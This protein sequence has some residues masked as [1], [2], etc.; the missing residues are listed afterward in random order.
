[1]LN[2]VGAGM[3]GDA[4]Q[5]LQDMDPG[6]AAEMAAKHKTLIVGFK[7]AHY[8]GPEWTPVENAVK[9]GETAGLPIMVDFG[10]FRPERPFE[11]LVTKNCA[12]ATCIH[13]CFCRWSRC[14]TIQAGCGL[15]CPRLANVESFST[16][17]MA[18]AV[19]C[20]GR[21]FPP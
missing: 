19:S 2:I 20:S 1:M 18:A 7:T 17:G 3:A 10:R 14:W 9:A 4:E 8:A 13:T 12:R 5:N 11:D 15:T 6:K 16:L 21:L